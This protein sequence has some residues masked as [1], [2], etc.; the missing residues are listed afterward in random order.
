MLA[1][2]PLDLKTTQ[3]WPDLR[4]R[5]VE[6]SESGGLPLIHS[7]PQNTGSGRTMLVTCQKRTKAPVK[8]QYVFFS[9]TIAM[10]DDGQGS[11][12][13]TKRAVR[14]N[15]PVC[16]CPEARIFPTLMGPGCAQ[17]TSGRPGGDTADHQNEWG[18]EFG[19]RSGQDLVACRWLHCG[20]G[21]EKCGF[22][23]AFHNTLNWGSVRQF[24]SSTVLT[25]A[26]GGCAQA[27]CRRR[28][29]IT[30]MT[31]LPARRRHEG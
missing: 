3:R 30:T 4:T 13:S 18:S 15:P 6:L 8:P 10:R 28:A 5:M 11:G 21:K 9:V 27:T 23:R 1:R 14:T 22:C 20:H 7:I 17:S 29:M 25:E 24:D 26:A 19:V 2:L 12:F 31:T 16:C